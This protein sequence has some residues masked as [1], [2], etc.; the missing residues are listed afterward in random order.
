MWAHSA[1]RSIYRQAGED[2]H[3]GHDD[4]CDDDVYGFDDVAGDCDYGGGDHDNGAS[5][6]LE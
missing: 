2:G 3:D 5:K 6:A 1:T 4:G